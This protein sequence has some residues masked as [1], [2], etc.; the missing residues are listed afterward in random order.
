[1]AREVRVVALLD[2]RR[3]RR[4]SGHLDTDETKVSPYYLEESVMLRWKHP[5]GTFGAKVEGLGG[6]WYL[7][8]LSVSLPRPSVM[9]S[10]MMAN[11]RYSGGD[12]ASTAER[13]YLDSISQE[14]SDQ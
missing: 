3:A 14:S 6:G 8:F 7:L 13:K 4:R 5:T 12:H 2:W 1:M 11:V 9:L 10:P